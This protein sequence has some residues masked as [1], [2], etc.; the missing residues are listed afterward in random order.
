MWCECAA[1]GRMRPPSTRT[2]ASHWSR[3]VTLDGFINTH[4]RTHAKIHQKHVVKWTKREDY[5]S[6]PRS[7]CSSVIYVYK[8]INIYMYTYI[9]TYEYVYLFVHVLTCGQNEIEIR[10][11]RMGEESLWWWRLLLLLLVVVSGWRHNT[12]RRRLPASRA[13]RTHTHIHPAN[14]LEM[15]NIY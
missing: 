7:T 3:V 14:K 11:Q 4:T 12:R 6:R 1:S 5:Y 2:A 9:Y 10:R 15:E 8:Y 13:S